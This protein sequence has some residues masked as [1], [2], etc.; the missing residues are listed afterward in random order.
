M[1]SRILLLFVLAVC[2]GIAG[3]LY[4]RDGWPGPSARLEPASPQQAILDASADKPGDAGLGS[5]FDELNARH[6]SGGLPNVKLLWDEDLHR[7]DDGDYRQNG[8]TDGKTILLNAALRE[9]DAEVRR[10]LCHEMVHVKFLAAGNRSTAHDGPF[11]SELRRIFDDGCFQAI[12]ASPDERASLQEWIDSERT[13][14]D[15][16]RAQ[17]DARIA[18]VKVEA[19]R[20]ERMFAELNERIARANAAGSGWPSRD[21]V[22]AAERQRTALNDSIVAYNS[23]VAANEGNQARFNEAVERYNLMVVYPDGLAEDR[24]KGLIR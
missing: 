21:E 24:A 12:W 9:D 5:L 11:Q 6:F 19:D 2:A 14:L 10:T 3:L 23:A 18:A 22:E 4:L 1:A 7:L 16:A 15:A 8:M 20:I 17:A 13:S